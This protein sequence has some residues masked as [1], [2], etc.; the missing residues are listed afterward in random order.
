MNNLLTF[1]T[2]YEDLSK[3]ILCYLFII[4]IEILAMELNELN[5]DMNLKNFLLPK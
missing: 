5:E 4:A 3:E 2:Q 1:S